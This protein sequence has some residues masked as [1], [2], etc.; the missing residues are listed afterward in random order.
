MSEHSIQSQILMA[1]NHGPVRLFRN[2]CGLAYAGVAQRRPG[3]VWI[4]NAYP[5]R[6]G[7]EN[8][9]ADL[10]GWR[11]VTVTPDM[12]GKKLAVFASVEVKDTKGRVRQDQQLWYEMVKLSGGLAVI[13]RSV[14]DANGVLE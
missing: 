14:E 5:I 10:I 6:Y 3:G 7:L 13:A 12:V 9:S 4:P 8:G 2:N 1:C 11:T